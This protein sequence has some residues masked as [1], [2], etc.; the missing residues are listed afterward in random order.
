MSRKVCTTTQGDSTCCVAAQ[1]GL[2]GQPITLTLRSG[3][4]RCGVCTVRASTSKRHPGAPVF[5]F[6]W[7]KSSTPGCNARTS[8]ACAALAQMGAATAAP[9]ASG[10][11]ALPFLGQPGLAF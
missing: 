9:A 11:A 10:L 7:I 8:A 5:Q 6:R 3:S 2:L 1:R 4:Q